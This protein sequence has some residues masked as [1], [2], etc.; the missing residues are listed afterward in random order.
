VFI[1]SKEPAPE[2]FALADQIIMKVVDDQQAFLKSP[3]ADEI[4]QQIP[5][6]TK[7]ERRDVL[8]RKRRSEAN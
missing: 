2:L 5:R 3:Y 4:R 7:F 6:L 8:P 1:V